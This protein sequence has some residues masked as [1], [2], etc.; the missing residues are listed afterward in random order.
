MVEIEETPEN[1][2]RDP[3]TPNQQVNKISK[4]N[5]VVGCATQM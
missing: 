3:D 1:K 2:E 5:T 4:S